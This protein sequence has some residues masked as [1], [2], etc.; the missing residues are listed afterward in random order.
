MDEALGEIDAQLLLEMEPEPEPEPE[1][2]EMADVIATFSSCSE[3][4]EETGSQVCE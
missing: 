1:V 3:G 4:E 2:H